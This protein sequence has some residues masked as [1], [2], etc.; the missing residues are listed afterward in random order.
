MATAAQIAAN[1]RNARKSTGPKTAQGKRASARNAVKYG[2]Y[3]EISE[4]ELKTIVEAIGAECSQMGLDVSDDATRGRAARLAVAEV[5]L[6]R[7]LQQERA[8]LVLGDDDLW[9]RSEFDLICDTLLEDELNENSLSES[10]RNQGYK[11][12]ERIAQIGQKSAA[13]AYRRTRK[14]L[15]ATEAAHQRALRNFLGIILQHNAIYN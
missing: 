5:R 13:R 8:T 3:S 10:E 1:R 9:L 14:T 6:A 7:A 4:A 2:L 12:L 11:H 15:A